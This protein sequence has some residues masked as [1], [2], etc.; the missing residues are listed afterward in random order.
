MIQ[1]KIKR[2]QR[3][4]MQNVKIMWIP[5]L[6]NEA[7]SQ[8]E[9]FKMASNFTN[10][11]ASLIYKSPKLPFS[12]SILGPYIPKSTILNPSFPSSIL[13]PYIPKFKLSPTYPSKFPPFH[14]PSRCVSMMI[15]PPPSSTHAQVFQPS[16]H[17]PCLP[18]NTPLT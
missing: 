7:K 1:N 4:K 18:P 9:S 3:L 2:P 17:Q 8:K 11:K 6:L 5:K 12:K 10:A 13:G 15:F 14:H 16:I